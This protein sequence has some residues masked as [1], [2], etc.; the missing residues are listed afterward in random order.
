[1]PTIPDSAPEPRI[2]AIIDVLTGSWRAACLYLGMK[3]QLPRHLTDENRRPRSVVALAAATGLPVDRLRRLLRVWADMGL[4]Y[5]VDDD[6]FALAE[7]YWWLVHDSGAHALVDLYES[8]FR[9][10]WAYA[11]SWL[12]ATSTGFEQAHE[13]TI[14]QRIW[15]DPAFATKFTG[16]MSALNQVF[17]VFADRL[18]SHFR[19]QWGFLDVGGG[20]RTLARTIQERAH[21]ARAAIQDLPHV[22][23]TN[24]PGVNDQI[25]EY[26]LDFFESVPAG[27]DCYLMSRVLQ[28]WDDDS[29]LRLLA[30][31]HSAA[32]DSDAHL[33][34][35]DRVVG[36][37][38]PL[39]N[40]WDV[41]LGCVAGGQHRTLTAYQSLFARANWT[42]IQ[43]LD[44]PL[45]SVAMELRPSRQAD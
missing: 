11:D 20:G 41:H 14:H 37:G 25:D 36:D 31:V 21:E 24:R 35:I 28:D 45:E 23:E 42:I 22:L 10:A 16:G 12:T 13:L 15:A 5:A 38:R 19:G 34:V 4:T 44:L 32:K 43:T 27:F 1:M 8:E 18:V 2:R 9:A 40:L 39:S 3:H 7:E 29:V 30:N 26:P 17:E 6:T 33:W